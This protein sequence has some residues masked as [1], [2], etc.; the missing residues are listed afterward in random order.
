[1]KRIDQYIE[2]EKTITPSPFMESR[3]MAAIENRVIL[4]E[5]THSPMRM[6]WQSAAIVVGIAILTGIGI[7][8]GNNYRQTIAQSSGVLM[9]N[10]N[11]IEQLSIYTADE[12]E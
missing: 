11:Y 10:D 12:N 8:T 4:S 3:I 7:A 1:M 2:E 6:V 9:V 5:Q